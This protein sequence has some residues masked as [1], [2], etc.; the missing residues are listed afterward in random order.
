M[1][2]KNF[3]LQTILFTTCESILEQIYRNDQ[4]FRSIIASS[5]PLPI[6]LDKRPP[7]ASDLKTDTDNLLDNVRAD[8]AGNKYIAK[9][10]EIIL[11]SNWGQLNC[12]GL[13]GTYRFINYLP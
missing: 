11:L 7:T 5:N 9:K 6:P 13:T 2:I 10:I 3:I 12:I 8:S 4:S 1:F